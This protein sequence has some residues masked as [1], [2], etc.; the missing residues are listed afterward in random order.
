MRPVKRHHCNLRE[1]AGGMTWYHVVNKAGT[2]C[3]YCGSRSIL[4]ELGHY[5]VSV[6]R[7][8]RR[9][10]TADAV[11]LHRTAEAAE[12]AYAELWP[13]RQD[14]ITRFTATQTQEV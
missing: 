8:D 13:Q 3:T 2:R 12:A 6:W 10:T 4:T 1:T 11:S 14:I 7:Q 5:T 9:Y